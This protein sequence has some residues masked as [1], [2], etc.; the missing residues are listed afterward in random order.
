MIIFLLL[1]AGWAVVHSLTAA[2]GLKRFFR[3]RFGEQAYAGWY[4]LLYNTISVLTFLPIYLLIPVLM[5]PT[6]LWEWTRP[7]T[8]LAYLLQI[9]G[10]IGLVYALWITDIWD[11]IGLR[12]T[13]WYLKGAKET[14]PTPQFITTGPYKL[15][16]HPLYFFSLLI[17]WFNP[18]MTT[19][20]FLFYCAATAYFF[21]GSIYEERK[22]AASF[23]D[24]YR[25]YQQ[26][27]PR[28]LPFLK[29]RP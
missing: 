10:L 25:T 8:Y 18:I 19:G 1:F 11:F 23:G 16:R 9:I 27:V 2:F 28:L 20:S 24:E 13:I 5:P 22:L 6:I 7:Y 21:I 26:R 15:V 14:I 3:S 12:Q 17:L 4:R 29:I